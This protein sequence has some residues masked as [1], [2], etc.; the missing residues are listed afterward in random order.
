MRNV[1]RLAKGAVGVR[2]RGGLLA[3]VMLIWMAALMPTAAH[4]ADYTVGPAPAWIVSVAPGAPTPDLVS[5]ASNGELYL[6]T[7]TQV[8][9]G[10]QHH[11]TYRRVVTTALN[12]NGVDAVANIEIPFDPAYQTL[13]LHSL[14]VV[15]NGHVISKLKTAR[16]QILQRE[17]ELEARVYDG[18][19]TVNVALD[20]VRVGDTVDYS[21]STTGRNPVFKGIEFGTATLQFA[22]P[23]ARVH[24]RML[25]PLE[26][27][28]A[29][30][31][32]NTA[33][34]PA[35]SEHDGLSDHV[36]DVVNP[37]VL[38][39]E[40][41]APDWYSPYAE[42]SWSEFSD[43]AAVAQWAQPLYEVPTTL[44]P[45][46]QAQVD[47][48]AK[49]EPT[50]AGRMLAALRLVQ[51]EVRYLGVEIGLNSQAPNSPA[52]VYARRFGDC[53]DKT[54]LTL[55]LLKHLGV[56]AH[57]ALVNTTLQRGLADMH[58]APGMFDHVLV[59]ARVDGKV[60]WIDPTRDTQNADLQ[61]L[62]QP[63]YGIA[64]VVDP[65]TKELTPMTRPSPSAANHHLNVVFDASAGLE[66]PVH[67]SL[68]TTT[69]GSA[70][71]SLRAYVSSTNLA[72]IQKKYLNFYA[73][74]Y[75]H[76]TV[77][78]PLQVRDDE[79]NNRIVS[80]ET[81]DIANILTYSSDRKEHYLTIQLRDIEQ[82]LFEP[83]V[84]VR[85]SPLRLTYPQDVSEDIDV[86]LPAS[87]WK[88]EPGTTVVDDPAFQFEQTVKL[89]GTHLFITE[90]Y[91]ALTD[92]VAT[93]EMPRYL[94]DLKR[95]RD[96]D[97]YQF[98]W[99]DASPATASTTGKASMLDRMNWPLVLLAMAMFAFWIWLA[100]V[101]YRYDPAPT[102]TA[103][104]RWVGI[105]GW[106]IVLAIGLTLRPLMYFHY[107]STVADVMSIDHWSKL[108]TFGSTHYNALWAPALLL[109]LATGLAQFVF[110]VL[111]LPLLFLRRSNFPRLAIVVLVSGFVLHDVNLALLHLIPTA[112]HPSGEPLK[113]I[114]LAIGVTIWSAYLLMS[115]RVK[116]TFTR[117]YRSNAAQPP[118]LDLENIAEANES[119]AQAILW[120]AKD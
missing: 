115:K 56:E 82:L 60:W 77:A 33:I 73:T 72:D 49:S 12:A 55:T 45:A 80:K 101:A 39:V 102:A 116:A 108:T 64:L 15:R 69:T 93:K 94:S 88:V 29:I 104:F 75:P 105:G 96:I 52:L 84:T 118:P 59:Q 65:H 120:P 86:L 6:L 74:G 8:L 44:S 109:E 103:D 111:L 14:D 25:S 46:L 27:H 34:K 42:V 36:W 62:V 70:A 32:R 107:L 76:I 20:D 110:S 23:V 90:H 17:T 31:A 18:T 2:Q 114:D 99:H 83:S 47:R 106:L 3:A 1:L 112:A 58:A 97:G 57:A 10:G 19:K 5:Q 21:Y 117:R 119:Q 40:D 37:P 95:A 35:M 92:E 68:E 71:E 79:P 53:K 50:P 9:A 78:A 22:V 54:L 43:W 98:M 67:Y 11:V 51:S 113:S 38:K 66:K 85:K 61:H 87:N 100:V 7:D 48:I 63:D 26:K 24:V 16:I 41:D 13:V 28:L 4:A 89:E 81:Y 30:T 91:Q